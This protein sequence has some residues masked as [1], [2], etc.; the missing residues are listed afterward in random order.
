MTDLIGRQVNVP[1]SSGEVTPGT[2][3]SVIKDDHVVVEFPLGDTYQGE[4]IPDEYR[5]KTGRKV[6]SIEGLE[7]I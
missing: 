4:K 3:V 7:F 5:G 2:I 1:R 6:L